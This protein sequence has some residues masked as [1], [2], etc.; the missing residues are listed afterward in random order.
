MSQIA[1]RNRTENIAP[2]LKTLRR[3]FL[4]SLLTAPPFV[5]LTIVYL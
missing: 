4:L 3:F 1:E 5:A 2:D